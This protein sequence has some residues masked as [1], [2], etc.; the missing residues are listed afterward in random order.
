MSYCCA[1]SSAATASS[2]QG[3]IR[4]CTI[5]MNY[6]PGHSHPAFR[7]GRGRLG[8]AKSYE[9][10]LAPELFDSVTHVDSLPGQLLFTVG[11][12]VLSCFGV[13]SPAAETACFLAGMTAKPLKRSS[14]R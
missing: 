12:R 2:S 4:G 5:S 11:K 1:G 9:P 10:M 6:K 7:K 3:L 13:G 8:N 14:T